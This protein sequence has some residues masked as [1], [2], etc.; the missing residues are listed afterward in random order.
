M[1]GTTSYDVDL[2]V[3]L[4][5][6]RADEA[7]AW[8]TGQWGIDRWGTTDTTTGDWVDVTCDVLD[9]LTMSAGSNTDDGV[10][11]RWESASCA[12]TLDGAAWDPWNGPHA[13]VV[14]DRVPVRVRWRPHG[15]GRRF[16]GLPMPAAEA[17]VPAFTG[18]VAARGYTWDPST[19]RAE[20]AC[21]DGT[22]VL[23]SSKSVP[24]PEQGDGESAA[25]RVQRIATKALWP[26]GYD[27]TAGGST[28]VATTLSAGAWDELL[29]VADT[30]L[31]LMWV[32]R[33]GVLAY[34]PRGRVGQGV[35]LT[36]RLA[37]CAA[38][39]GDVEVITIGA[40]QP[41]VNR[42]RVW[43]SHRKV[44]AADPDPPV[45]YL[46]DRQ[47]VARFQAQEFSRT[48]LWH[49]S[50]A[51]STTL[52]TAILGGGAWPSAAP[53]AALL[54]SRDGDERVAH[55]LLSLEPDMTFDLVDDAGRV[56]R[57]AVVGWEVTVSHAQID[58]TLA[59]ED[60]SRW[61]NP[62]TWGAGK[63]GID[64]WGIGGI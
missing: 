9:G 35:R 43:V 22:S 62:A 39:P 27:I 29:Q 21:V 41:T 26:G 64:R 48:D 28:L 61:A 11:R 2:I 10:T 18:Y 20:V 46:E 16:H 25:A 60:V 19:Q 33:A 12:F 31:A 57:Q 53:G 40:A 56:W 54:D 3:E 36:G 15:A 5:V 34:R 23:V 58:G 38:G 30:D 63:W 49:N 52:A 1:P 17:W 4:A 45:A 7:G 51:W 14:G 37:V 24:E 6:G 13:G 47:S 44:Q 59:L 8:G 55:L 42:N 50:D 32:T